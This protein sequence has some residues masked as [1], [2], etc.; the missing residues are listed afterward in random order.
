MD[1][2]GMELIKVLMNKRILIFKLNYRIKKIMMNS[3]K[4]MNKVELII[5]KRIEV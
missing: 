5:K 4:F 1:I 2:N 3:N